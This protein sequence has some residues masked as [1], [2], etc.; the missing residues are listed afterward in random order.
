MWSE[1]LSWNLKRTL[2]GFWSMARPNA[3]HEEYQ[4]AASASR[5]T[6]SLERG[7]EANSPQR[8]FS[9]GFIERQITSWAAVLIPTLPF[10]YL[11]AS[12][13]KGHDLVAKIAEDVLVLLRKPDW[14]VTRFE[15]RTLIRR[16]YGSPILG[17]VA[18][19]P[20]ASPEVGLPAYV[21][22][23]L[24]QTYVTRPKPKRA[25]D[26]Y[27]WNDYRAPQPS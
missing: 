13:V 16:S 19:R 22:A 6:P 27:A 11:L 18:T 10:L 9:D 14:K 2:I 3:F 7:A 23:Q 1:T 12:D 21:R 25:V 8:P 17:R 15:I 4:V 24:R 5:T 20:K 26:D